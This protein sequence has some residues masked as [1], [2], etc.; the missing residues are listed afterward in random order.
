MMRI[1][2]LIT[3]LLLYAAGLFSQERVYFYAPDSLKISAFLY[4]YNDDPDNNKPYI[5]LFHQANYSKGEYKETAPKL[6]KLGFNCLAVDL[7]S[8]G[9][10]N[11]ESNETASRA[12]AQ[13]LPTR[14]VNAEQDVR[15]AIEYK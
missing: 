12:Q 8:G 2:L 9:E 6:V 10:V 3:A 4:A 5:L 7:R 1:T 11:Y 13:G 15:A 14:Y